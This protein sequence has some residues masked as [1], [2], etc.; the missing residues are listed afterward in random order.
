MDSHCA[1]RVLRFTL[2]VLHFS[3]LL[4][5]AP[6]VLAA[7][8]AQSEWVHSD[9][10]G[11]LVYKTT[12]HGDRIMDFS[13]AGYMGGGVALPSVRVAVT[14]K[15]TGTADDSVA[16]QQAIDTIS[17]REPADG[18][19]GAV[20][21]APGAYNCSKALAIKA[22]GVV[23]RGS[24]AGDD[25]TILKVTGS[26]HVCITIA[27]S[28]S[29]K[30]GGAPVA[31]TDRYIPAGASSVTVA[32][33]MTFKAG[34]VVLVRKPVTPA[35]VAFMGMDG[36]VRNGKKETWATGDIDAERAI[37]SVDGNRL[38]FDVPLPDS[39]DAAH[40]AP[41]GA[42]VVKATRADRIAQVGVESL[43]IVSPARSAPISE[44]QH[45]AIRM[46]AV[47]DGWLRDLRITD[48]VNS[49]SIGSEAR[50]VTVRGV[51][52]VHTL[53]T[54]GAAKPAD[55]M[56][57]GSQVLIDRCSGAGDN[58]FYFATGGKVTGPIVLLNCTFRGDGHIQPHM[59]WA[60]GLLFDNCH[61]DAAGIDLMNRGQ[62][63]SGHGWTA[64]WSV[65]WNCTA[66]SFVIQNPPGSLNWA[67]GCRGEQLLAPMPF[68][69]NPNLPQGIID[70]SGAPVSPSSLYLAQLRERLG[71]DALHHI[72]Y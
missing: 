33:A 70:S 8:E 50:R 61:V 62:M 2:Q 39:Y 55:I 35:W 26:P 54:T 59:R 38:T 30:A 64:G 40:L 65:A 6:A 48:T 67:I 41:P 71:A 72:G 34:D 27:G 56:V 52:M 31:I 18:F 7:D 47:A 45:Q 43:S 25:G 10:T 44:R 58:I 20:L 12:D 3:L 68:E 32:D 29:T 42:S 14:V 17:T 16:I 69:K 19:R 28:G 23:L 1:R 57:S 22:C 60:T 24:G 9:A 11:R 37:A 46:N 66:K 15:P 21:L 51:E 53:P 36:L 4:F 63:G 13:S 49:V 5:L